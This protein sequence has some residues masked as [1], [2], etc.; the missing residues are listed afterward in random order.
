MLSYSGNDKDLGTPNH[1]FGGPGFGAAGRK[2]S[3]VENAVSQGKV[4]IISTDGNSADPNDHRFG[5]YI[6]FNFQE[7][8]ELKDI[9]LLDNEEDT[10]FDVVFSDGN[11]FSLVSDSVGTC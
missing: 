3:K 10:A 4:L 2:G 8:V 6:Q 5:G 1:T 7:P 11:T 9:G